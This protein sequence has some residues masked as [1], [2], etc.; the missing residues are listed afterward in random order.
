[1]TSPVLVSPEPLLTSTHDVSVRRRWTAAILFGVTALLLAGPL[2]FGG[3]EAWAIF[4]LELGS[5]VLFLSWITK[6]GYLNEFEIIR[7]PLFA[8]MIAFGGLIAM[9]WVF[10]LTAYRYVTESEGLLYAAYGMI[11][12]VVTQTLRRG[13]QARQVAI[14]A[15]VYGATVA[16]FALVQGAASN[17]RIY[18]LRTTSTG[19]WIYGPYVNHNHYAALMEMLVP[20]PLVFVLT[21][22]A[23]GNRKL[24]AGIAAALMAST[25]FLSGSR[26]GMIS[27]VIEIALLF[28]AIQAK[29]KRPRTVWIALLTLAASVAVVYWLEGRDFI[30]RLISIHSETQAEISGG[31]RFSIVRDG[32]HMFVRHPISGW[33]LGTFPVVYPQFR[34]FYTN[35]F[36]NQAHNDYLQ[37]LIETG[38]LGFLAAA[39]FLVRLY[40]E[41]WKKIEDWT[42]NVNS[43]VALAALIACTGIVAHSLVDFNLQIP[44]NAALFYVL[45]A[46]AAA[47]NFQE[48]SHRRRHRSRMTRESWE[49]LEPLPDSAATA[50]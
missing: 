34:S 7:N 41:T 42:S 19:G 8:P 36:I 48:P 37:L 46:I 17:G 24:L 15:T 28:V 22:F 43:A 32:L 4:G 30:Q 27:L 49:P 3:V 21:S 10:G 39:W 35:F 44:A 14:I 11:V 13:S 31:T 33:G 20:I 12:F 1:V 23:S 29:D 5:G 6:Q 40:R 9:Q 38:L 45:A 16:L 47:P 18:W 50:K 2:A 25:I 26:G